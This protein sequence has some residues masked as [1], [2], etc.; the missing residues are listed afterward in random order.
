MKR[1][2]IP[3]ALPQS[4]PPDRETDRAALEEERR[5]V[6]SGDRDEDFEAVGFDDGMKRL[7]EVLREIKEAG[8]EERG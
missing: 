6:L 8:D 3:S 1:K 5:K 4:P 7:A 2:K